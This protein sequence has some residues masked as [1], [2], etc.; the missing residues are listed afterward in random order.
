M[1]HLK[2]RLKTTFG[3]KAS[4][5]FLIVFL[6]GFTILNQAVA[7]PHLFIVQRLDVVFD[8][9]GLTGIRVIWKMDD[10]FAEMVAEDYDA[11]RNGV[12]EPEEVATVK[13]KA[14]SYISEYDYF[15]FI[16]I[17]GAPFKVKFIK[18]FNAVLEDGRLQ[19]EFTIPCH[20][21]ATG[22]AK[23][24]AV[25]TYD[26]TYYTAIFFADR[27]PVSLTDADAY[28]VDASVKEDPDTK[29]YYDMVHPWTL[30]LEFKRKS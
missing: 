16:K 12:L 6:A 30:F 25:S 8:D 11:N 10:M 13:E 2:S 4:L 27:G 9:K 3:I 22:N 20:V 21:T 17:D 28:E 14:F 23:R 18:D 19:Y 24:I 5:V 7:H 26:P 15:S 1:N 29:I